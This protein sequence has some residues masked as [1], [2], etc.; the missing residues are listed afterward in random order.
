MGWRQADRTD[1]ASKNADVIRTEPGA[2]RLDFDRI[3][4]MTC[5]PRNGD[6]GQNR[7]QRKVKRS[8]AGQTHKRPLDTKQQGQATTK[9]PTNGDRQRFILGKVIVFVCPSVVSR[10]VVDGTVAHQLVIFGERR[11]QQ[12]RRRQRRRNAKAKETERRK[13]TPRNYQRHRSTEPLVV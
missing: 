13:K 6:G 12:Q 1:H 8:T 3:G 11:R 2:I 10:R 4:A 5:T 9:A 7:T